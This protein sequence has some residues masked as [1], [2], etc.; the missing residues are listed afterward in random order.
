MKKIAFFLFLLAGHLLYGQDS[1]M[2][3]RFIKKINAS[4]L[5]LANTGVKNFTATV[6][7]LKMDK[8]CKENWG[9]KQIFPLQLIWISPERIYLSQLGVPALSQEKTIEYQVLLDGLKQQMKGILLDL[10]RFYITGI[11][12][13][14]GQ[15]YKLRNNE[16]A[17]QIT[18]KSG[19]EES[20]SNVKYLFGLNGLCLLNEINYTKENKIITIY[21]KFMT[22]DNKWLCQG[23]T[24]Q[25]IIGGQV[26][27]GYKLDISYA[28]MS[29]IWAPIELNI[30]VQITEKPG[31]TYYDQIQIKNYMFNQALQFNEQVTPKN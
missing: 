29:E 30:N 14:F 9:D 1:L 4:Y 8:F 27:N 16:E 7:S 19:N 25:T 11:N 5:L 12:P 13:G 6:S 18:F 28:K 10:V 20:P 17:V 2:Q 26:Q 23:W 22:K 15:D 21:P 24:V 31:A 3:D